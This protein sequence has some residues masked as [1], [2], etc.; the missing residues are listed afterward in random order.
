MIVVTLIDDTSEIAQAIATLPESERASTVAAALALGFETLPVRRVLTAAG[1]TSQIG[2]VREAL[3]AAGTVGVTAQDLG[4]SASVTL[5]S[6]WTRCEIVRQREPGYRRIRYWRPASAPTGAQRFRE[7][8][9]ASMTDRVAAYV[10]GMPGASLCDIEDA[11]ET[12]EGGQHCRYF[13]GDD[14]KQTASSA[15]TK[16]H[17]A[18]RLKRYQIAGSYRYFA[19]DE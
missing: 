10:A 9:P 14:Q 17:D 5:H 18:G 3:E 15:L 19:N 6:L 13:Y 16:L 1:P 8:L 7:D 4:G 12:A 11:V 2:R